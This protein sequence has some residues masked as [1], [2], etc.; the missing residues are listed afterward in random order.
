MDDSETDNQANAYIAPGGT[1]DAGLLLHVVADAD[2]PNPVSLF[3]ITFVA[4]P[5][6]TGT[7]DSNGTD[8]V[9]SGYN[10]GPA[11]SLSVSDWLEQLEKYTTTLLTGR[12]GSIG[13]TYSQS[14]G[15]L[16]EDGD[17]G[18]S[19]D[20]T[21]FTV[22]NAANA[23]IGAGALVN[24]HTSSPNQNVEVEADTNIETI[25]LAGQA[26]LL[27][28]PSLF[29]G[30]AGGDVGVGGSFEDISY[31][32]TAHAYIDNKAKVS[33]GGDINV[34]A[35]TYN[36]L[37]NLAQSGA[38]SESLAVNG[39]LIYFNLD[40]D[41]E[42]WIDA[43]ATINAGGDVGVTAG[44]TLIDIVGTGG[45]A[46]GG[47]AGVGFSGSYNNLI[48]T[49]K[50]FIGTTS[51]TTSPL[52]SVTG[53]QRPYGSCGLEPGDCQ[54]RRLGRISPPASPS[55]PAPTAVATLPPTASLCPRRSLSKRPSPTKTLGSAF[56]GDVGL[57][58]LDGDDRSLYQR[59]RNDHRRQCTGRDRH[60]YSPALSG[61]R[62]RRLREPHWHRRLG[63][64][65]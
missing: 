52:G 5:D 55:L 49:T 58:F 36:Y 62:G 6:N 65:R 43:G 27:S 9:T 26:S 16:G 13:T 42:G 11:A 50:A 56:S 25:N 57:N 31:N 3:G 64:A 7:N 24:Q 63:H 39:A 54:R 8:R 33:A 30:A 45:I 15:E 4:P 1:V 59:N 29:A 28:V 40:N 20:V 46:V 37:L 41:T 21:I 53:R 23:Y 35:N 34:N 60:R 17:F 19:G 14:E 32:N 18:I 51:D 12:L 38:N 10:A 22:T 47:D 2:I 44:D 61:R 48:D